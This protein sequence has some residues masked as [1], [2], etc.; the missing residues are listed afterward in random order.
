MRNNCLNYIYKTM[1]SYCLKCK[2]YV[3]IDFNTAGI[4]GMFYKKIAKSKFKRVQ[5]LKQIQQK[6]Y[7]LNEKDLLVCLIA[8]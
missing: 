8:R 1:K 6:N 4:I 5:R 3:I 2:T 7:M